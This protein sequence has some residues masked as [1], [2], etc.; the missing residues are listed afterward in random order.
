VTSKAGAVVASIVLLL[1]ALRLVDPVLA[2]TS[3]KV[4]AKCSTWGATSGGLTCAQVDA[5]GRLVWVRLPG[6]AVTVPGQPTTTSAGVKVD[7]SFRSGGGVVDVGAEPAVVRFTADCSDSCEVKPK[8]AAG[9]DSYSA[10]A[11]YES[12]VS[13]DAFF[14]VNYGV[15]DELT[16]RLQ[17]KAKSWKVQLLALSSVPVAAV[18]QRVTGS[19]PTVFAVQGAP[20]LVSVKAS[21]KVSLV[22]Y[23]ADRVS[24]S[25]LVQEFKP[26]SGEVVVPAGTAYLWVDAVGSWDFT[27]R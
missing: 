1:A 18:G 20:T 11:I 5:K 21:K 7:A 6:P 12:G 16:T 9:V 23:S 2:A 14:L 3:A 26:F 8:K 25:Y 17:V 10:P 27:L 24:S 13:L 19:Q 4:G 22:S 15:G